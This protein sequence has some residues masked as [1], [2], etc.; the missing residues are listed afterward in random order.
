M[1]TYINV[2]MTSNGQINLV[3]VENILKCT[4]QVICDTSDTGEAAAAA[5]GCV[6]GPVQV[7]NDPRGDAPVHCCQVFCDEPA[8]IHVYVVSIS[9]K[10]RSG[11]TVDN[12]PEADA[13]VHC[14]QVSCDEPAD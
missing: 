12:D 11:C 5:G 14:C 1:R 10:I 6:D 9:Y 7:H 3:L 13:P 4:S 8:R 2:V